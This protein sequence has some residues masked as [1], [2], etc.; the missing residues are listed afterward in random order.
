MF[1]PDNL[2]DKSS[3]GGKLESFGELSGSIGS[4]DG[5]INGS[6]EEIETVG[7]IIK[8][9][10]YKGYS[11]FEVAVN[12]GFVGTESEWL[13]SL[14][15]SLSEEDLNNVIK[16]VEEG[17]LNDIFIPTKVSELKNDAGYLSVE[18]DPTVP[19]HVKSITTD[20]INRWNSKSEFNGDYNSLL[21]KPTIPT[22]LPASDVYD[23]AKASSKPIYTAKEV[24]AISESLKG[25]RNGLAELD[26]SG[27]VLLNQIPENVH[28]VLVFNDISAFPSTG[29]TKKIYVDLEYKKSYV[30]N[31][32]YYVELSE[33]LSLGY[34]SN[35]AYPGN[36]GADIEQTVQSI[37]NGS[38]SVPKATTASNVNGY[39][40]N[41]SVPENAVFTDTVYVHPDTHSADMIIETS[42]R[43]FATVQQLEK[44][45]SIPT[46]AKFTDTTYDEAT[47]YTSGLMSHVDKAKLDGIA[48]NANNYIHPDKHL[49]DIIITDETHRF[50]TD[51]E[52][53]KLA[54]LPDNMDDYKP[55]VYNVAT[56]VTN[57]LMSKDDKNKL[58]GIAD[59]AN[60]FVYEHPEHH[61]ASMITESDDRKFITSDLLAKLNGIEAN[62]N[63]YTHPATHNAS[64]IV[65]DD[66]HKFITS[67]LYS[68]LANIPNDAK[69][70]D[71]TYEM[72]SQSNNGIMSFSDKI[73]LDGIESNANNYVHPD[74]HPASMITSDVDHRFVNDTQLAK[75]NAIPNDPK[76]TD[77]TY[78]VA[79][80]NKNGLMSASDKVKLNGI[81]ESAN[82]YV[83]PTTHEPSIIAED[84]AHRFVSDTDKIYWDGK[85]DKVVATTT[86]NGLMSSTDK[87]NLDD[88][89]SR[90]SGASIITQEEK[91]KL[92]NIIKIF[93][94]EEI[95]II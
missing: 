63:N 66:N 85:A 15:A 57:G 40:V 60:Y 9:P 53:N 61:A 46:D 95:L 6:I 91:E 69:Y 56:S 12:N 78:N 32:N 39:M 30:W 38:L 51:E 36:K 54:L 86:A 28:D 76:Y 67:E 47:V 71:T 10:I 45:A 5:T 64:M 58:D 31:G 41:K 59:N 17:I 1:N 20:D 92:L 87:V 4:A 50:I 26:S 70:T 74:T 35:Q 49:A 89:V 62:A 34:N 82:N 81:D 16:N 44:L 88:V 94:E 22:T 42:T 43:R 29:E 72:V 2:G 21:N 18:N 93:D 75:I 73:K 48:E 83:H 23:W 37:V 7:G 33:T 90:M 25:A 55:I 84:E 3:I 13:K 77:T 65:E 24:G 8:N 79:T 19:S 14:H 52:L 27:K 68:K 11:A 80:I